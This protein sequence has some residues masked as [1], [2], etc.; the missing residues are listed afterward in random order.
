[1]GLD[2]TCTEIVS[3]PSTVYFMASLCSVTTSLS[4]TDFFC[5]CEPV[6]E[7]YFLFSGSIHLSLGHHHGALMVYLSKKS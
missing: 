4:A 7:L 3:Y 5:M 6:S 1:M 2:P